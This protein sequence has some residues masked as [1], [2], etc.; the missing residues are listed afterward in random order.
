MQRGTRFGSCMDTIAGPELATTSLQRGLLSM[1]SPITGATTDPFRCAATNDFNYIGFQQ[2]PF[3]GLDLQFGMDAEADLPDGPTLAMISSHE[4]SETPLKA[5]TASTTKQAKANADKHAEVAWLKGIVKARPGWM[6]FF[7][8]MNRNL[9]N[10]DIVRSWRFAVA[11]SNEYNKVESD[12]TVSRILKCNL[13]LILA[14][15]CPGPE[16]KTY[17]EELYQQSTA[18]WLNVDVGS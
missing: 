11:F 14:D 7:K 15:P 12:I 10:P 4:D 18:P 1:Y 16:G 6:D 5:K 9:E 3:P 2:N 17:S 13:W 8:G